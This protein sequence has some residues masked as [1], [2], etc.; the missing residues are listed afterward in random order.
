MVYFMMHN[1]LSSNFIQKS[2]REAS[3]RSERLALAFWNLDFTHDAYEAW[4]IK[5]Q[6]EALLRDQYIDFNIF[7]QVAKGQALLVGE[8]NLSFSLS[9]TQNPRVRPAFLTAT[10]REASTHLSDTAKHNA[11]RLAQK[12]ARVLHGIDATKLAQ[13]FPR[14]A[15]QTILFQFPNVASREP[16]QG[17]NPNFVLVQRFLKSAKPHLVSGGRII[18]SV[19]DS[20]YYRGLFHFEE[21]A[22]QAGF[23][24]PHVAT[25]D[26]DDFPGYHHT[27][28]HEEESAIDDYEHFASYIFTKTP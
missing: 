28:T 8:G 6:A 1:Q 7:D 14:Q 10:T 21:A 22:E 16:I 11:K 19:V 13:D 3:A 26:P 23:P 12:G 2:L 15:F 24:P 27:M 17:L 20:P 18:I 5:R 9:L 25:F 4:C